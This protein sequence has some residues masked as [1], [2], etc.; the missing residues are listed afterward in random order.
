MDISQIDKNF[1]LNAIKETNIVWINALQTPISLH[2][3]YFSEEERRYRRMPKEVADSVNNGVSGLA[4]YTAGGRVRFITD[5]PYVAFKCVVPQNAIMAHMPISG[6]FGLGVYENNVF[7]GRCSPTSQQMIGGIDNKCAFEGI[8]YTL[9]EGEKSVDVYLP[10]YGGLY[11]LYIGI[12]EGSSLKAPKPYAHPQ[13]VVFYGSSITQGGCAS[14]PGSDYIGLLCR[15]L[16]TEVYNLGFSG[17]AR[18]EKEMADYLAS[19]DASVFVLDY[20]WNAPTV[21]HLQ[22]THLPLYETIRK[23]HPT[24]PIIFITKPDYDSNPQLSAER[25]DVIRKTY[26]IALSRGDT[27]VDFIDGETLFGGHGRDGCSADCCHPNDLGFYR[28][29]ERIAPVLQNRLEPSKGE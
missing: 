6:S 5:S 16:D 26:E 19:L 10:L 2:G 14:V 17:S 23:A 1:A 25:R 27:L 11:D 29:A 22:A 24:T 13:Q 21:E 9:T 28:M 15:W 7:I 3:V 12:K 4:K 8:L 18:G 20:D